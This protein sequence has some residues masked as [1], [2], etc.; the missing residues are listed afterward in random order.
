MTCKIVRERA[1]N[2]PDSLEKKKRE[3]GEEKT[4]KEIMKTSETNV[5]MKSG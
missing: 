4:K 2:G 5:K 3:K 1:W